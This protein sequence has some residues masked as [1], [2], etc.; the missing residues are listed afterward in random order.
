MTAGAR[1]GRFAKLI[2]P[3]MVEKVALAALK[4]EVRPR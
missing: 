4:E 2:V 3:G 1:L